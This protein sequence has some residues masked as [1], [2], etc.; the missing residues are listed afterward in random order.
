MRTGKPLNRWN[1]LFQN[2]IPCMGEDGTLRR[3]PSPIHA[4]IRHWHGEE[5]V[6]LSA[7]NIVQISCLEACTDR[8]HMC[9]RMNDI[10]ATTTRMHAAT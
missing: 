8:G 6:H 9:Q 3:T 7:G 5:F 2:V 1:T 10:Q 4:S